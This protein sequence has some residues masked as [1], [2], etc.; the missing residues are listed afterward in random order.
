VTQIK[1]PTY[2]IAVLMTIVIA[3]LTILIC[4][5]ILISKKLRDGEAHIRA[6]IDSITDG[7]IA[8]DD[9]GR[10]ESFNIGAQKMFGYD[11]KELLGQN[12]SM[13]VADSDR[14]MH[15]DY[16]LNYHGTGERKVVAKG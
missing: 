1:I 12:D 8:V 11:K 10:I 5:Q 16:I 4:Q 9:T 3:V 2:V 7:I 13:P 15:K 14:S 6:I